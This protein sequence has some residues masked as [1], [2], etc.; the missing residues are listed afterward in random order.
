MWPG[1]SVKTPSGSGFTI[2]SLAFSSILDYPLLFISGLC[3]TCPQIWS[4]YPPLMFAWMSLINAFIWEG[5]LPPCVCFNISSVEWHF[6]EL[7][8]WKRPWCWKRL[9]EGGKRGGRGWDGWMTSPTQWTWVWVNSQSWWWTG[10]PGVLQS[11]VGHDWVTELNTTF[12]I[13]NM[14]TKLYQW[15][16][17]QLEL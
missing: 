12:S 10:K 15:L 3:Q 4:L 11:I 8:H 9:K 5:R 14:K 1:H 2:G 6:Q 13:R 17:V 7:T 16:L